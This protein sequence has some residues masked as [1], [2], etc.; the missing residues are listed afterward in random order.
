M[1]K[2]PIKLPVVLSREEVL[3]FLG[4]VRNTKHRAML[5]VAYEAGLRITEV[6]RVRTG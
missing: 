3:H 2:Q 4:S 1:P 5:T 6:V